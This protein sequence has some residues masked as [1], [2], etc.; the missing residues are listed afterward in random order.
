MLIDLNITV[1]IE[2]LVKE[3]DKAVWD[4]KNRCNLNKPT[5]NWLFDSYEI[6]PEWKGSAFDTLLSGLP[7][8]IGEARLM[9]LTPGTCYPCHSDLDDRYHINLTSNQQSYL[10]DLKNH[11]MHPVETDGKIYL[12]N[13]NLLH[14]AVNFGDTDRIQLVIRKPFDR[15]SDEDMIEMTVKFINP[16]FN[17]RY[18]FDQ[19]VSPVIG[20]LAKEKELSWFEPTSETNMIVKTTQDG[21]NELLETFNEC[22]FKYLTSISDKK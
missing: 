5:G 22:G 16:K 14:T 6:L 17:F 20:K 2:S 9:K 8:R 19:R 7:F 18:E 12:M 10:I 21:I 3:L 4:S 11:V 15:I 1:D 13:A